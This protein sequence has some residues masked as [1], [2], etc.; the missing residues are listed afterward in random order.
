MCSCAGHHH[1]VHVGRPAGDQARILLAL[2][3]LPD[4]AVAAGLGFLDDAHGY[5]PACGVARTGSGTSIGAVSAA[6]WRSAAD[7]TAL[8]ML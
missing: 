1:V 6:R 3:R 8:T 7:R 5:F 4:V 2:E